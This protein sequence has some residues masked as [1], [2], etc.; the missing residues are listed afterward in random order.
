LGWN[1]AMTGAGSKESAHV[2]SVSQLN[3]EARNLLET[4]LPA[5]WVAGEISNL[6]SP[7]SGHLYFTLKDAQAQV[8][9]AMFRS[10]NRQLRFRMEDGVQVL[11]QARV[12]LYEPRGTYQLIVSQMEEAGEGL[13]RRKFEELKARL[14]AE[15]LFAAEHKQA[16]PQLPARIG[17]VTSPSG[18]AIRDIL[19]VLARRY[20]VAEVYIYPTRVQGDGVQ[21]EI[22]RAIKLATVRNECDVLIIA[23][24]GGS[25]EDLWCFN[26]E[27]VARAIYACPI[28]VVS[29]VGHEVDFT[30]ADLVADVRAPTPSGAAELITPDRTELLRILLALDRRLS[31]SIR[32][33]WT[34]DMQRHE[35]LAARLQRT[36]PGI[37]LERLQQR[38][39][40]LSR[41]L[42]LAMRGNLQSSRQRQ[43]MLMQRLR[44]AVPAARITQ[45]SSVVSAAQLRLVNAIRHRLQMAAGR[46]SMAAGELHA[47]S[48]LATLERGYAVV[49]HADSGRLV[50]SVN[51][52]VKGDRIQA[53]LA[54]GILE[55]R[56]EKILRKT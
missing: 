49:Q 18:A 28:P 29:G 31:L 33:Q 24:G 36:H 6:A 27:I 2:Y 4:T 3:G 8:R 26:E 51:D 22:A 32:R 44:S 15:G 43:Q 39:D 42:V 21:E 20:P 35:R 53:R 19:H 46:L 7:G 56:V 9:C 12:S 23:R 40:E 1:T 11:V 54:R 50:R 14:A 5:V 30:I 17:V 45:Y 48:P 47:V 16:L 52:V 13:L 25:L 10:A 41:Q 55:A 38:T 34:I 37:V